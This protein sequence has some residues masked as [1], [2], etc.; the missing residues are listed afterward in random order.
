MRDVIKKDRYL[1]APK[2]RRRAGSSNGDPIN[3]TIDAARLYLLDILFSFTLWYGQP[4]R[5]DHNI[6]SLHPVHVHPGWILSPSCFHRA[7]LRGVQ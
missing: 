4:I 6:W 1:P 5:L 2:V 3:F 7:A